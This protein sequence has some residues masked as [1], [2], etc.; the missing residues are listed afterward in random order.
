MVEVYREQD[1]NMGAAASQEITF[2]PQEIEFVKN[3]KKVIGRYA[4]RAI[5]VVS[6]VLA[7]AGI[8]ATEKAEAAAVTTTCTT[9]ASSTWDCD[10]PIADGDHIALVITGSKTCHAN[11][12]GGGVGE[13]G[14]FDVHIVVDPMN[15]NCA[16]FGGEPVPVDATIC[17]ADAAPE[18]E[19][20]PIPIMGVGGIAKLPGVEASPQDTNSIKSK[21]YTTPIAA[22]VAAAGAIAAAGATLYIHRKRPS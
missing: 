19:P 7:G 22:G 20:T 1:T 16:T 8:V 11:V 10:N 17:C 2:T 13:G 14:S 3:T 12:F 4:A 6:A 15:V 21:D 5:L 18:P 9:I